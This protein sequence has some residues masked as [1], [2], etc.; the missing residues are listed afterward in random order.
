MRRGL[1][2]LLF[3]IAAV[4]LAL[5]AGGWWLQRVAFDTSTSGELADVVMRDEA[6]RSEVSAVIADA[7]A[8]TLGVPASD[9]RL[10][11]EQYVQADDPQ[12]RATLEDIVAQSHARL[13]GERAEPVQIT[14]AQIVPIVRADAAAALPPITL[15]VQEVGVLSAIRTGLG[16]F[17]PAVAIVG[18]VAALAGLI[19]HPRKADAVTGIGLFLIIGAIV[20]VLLVYVV[21]VFLLPAFDDST[22][23]GVIPAIA[24]HSM[25]IVVSA[26][27]VLAAAGVALLV[28]S[29]A[30]RRRR[31]WR[32]PVTMSRYQDQRRWS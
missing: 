9:L 10:L 29:A 32:S 8:P 23:V 18:V 6:I 12:I 26:A 24:R 14:G 22:W 2:G 3:F 7:A 31:T 28:L 15:P 27:L 5:A 21:P 25:P 20:A 11:V 16:W 17:V 1:A 19:A 13:I 4:C 30:S